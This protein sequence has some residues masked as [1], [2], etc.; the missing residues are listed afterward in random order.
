MARAKSEPTF[1]SIFSQAKEVLQG[2]A[3]TFIPELLHDRSKM[4]LK[5]KRS[6]LFLTEHDINRC[7]SSGVPIKICDLPFP[8]VVV[9][10]EDG[11]WI[12]GCV[13]RNPNRPFREVELSYES[14]FVL[15]QEL[16][17]RQDQL[18]AGQNKDLMAHLQKEMLKAQPGVFRP[19]GAPDDKEFER[20]VMEAKQKKEEEENSRKAKE[21]VATET[22]PLQQLEQ[23]EGKAHDSEDEV[24]EAEVISKVLPTY[25]ELYKTVAGEGRRGGVQQ[26]QER[27]EKW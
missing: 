8:E 9:Q 2:K 22:A 10:D 3:A 24:D 20:I 27:P 1:A 16:T 14:S 17:Q 12:S 15:Q 11:Q 6:L 13:M 5:C 18:R 4:S 25:A 21:S 23:R 19:A 7:Y 26:R